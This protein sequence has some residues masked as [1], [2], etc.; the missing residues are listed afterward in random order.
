MPQA[1]KIPDAK[2][3]VDKEWEK[4]EKLLAWQSKQSEE[5]KGGHSGSTKR[6]NESP[7]CHIDGHLSSQ[8]SWVW[9]KVTKVHRTSRA[10]RRHWKTTRDLMRY[11]QNKV[12][13]RLKWRPWKWYVLLE[14][15]LI[16]QDKQPMQYLL[17]PKKNWGRSKIAQ[18]I[19]KSECPDIWVRL[20]R[21]TNGLNHGPAWKIESFLLNDSCTVIL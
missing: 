2:A 20:P 15:Y 7:L 18:K 12:H 14:G 17:T 5:Q 13:L 10:Q 1:I 11:S 16:V 6:E 19:P 21:N 8:Q 4:L 9:T 3:A